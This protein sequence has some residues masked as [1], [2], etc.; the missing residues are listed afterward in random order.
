MARITAEG[1]QV[2]AEAGGIG[3]GALGLGGEGGDVAFMLGGEPCDGL[4]IGLGGARCHHRIDARGI[5]LRA[6]MPG[7]ETC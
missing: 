7:G 3:A 2:G 4:R 6:E 1:L 5:A